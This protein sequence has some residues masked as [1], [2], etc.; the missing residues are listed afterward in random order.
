MQ[1][2]VSGEHGAVDTRTRAYV[3]YRVFDRLRAIEHDVRDVEVS[4][5]RGRA[6]A[7]GSISCSVTARLATGGV[8]T[9]TAE[10]DWPYKAIDE[11][12]RALTRGQTR[13][14]LGQEV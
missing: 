2:N 7:P 9:A 13:A 1:I 5:R 4:L 6:G 8:I 3:E 11:A 14:T 10:A 12:V